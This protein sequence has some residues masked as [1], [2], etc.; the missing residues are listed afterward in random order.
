[1]IGA[2]TIYYIERRHGNA[3]D[4]SRIVVYSVR[5]CRSFILFDFRG[6]CQGGCSPGTAPVVRPVTA[7]PLA[8]R[9]DEEELGMNSQHTLIARYACSIWRALAILAA[10]AGCQPSAATTP[11]NVPSSSEASA[12]PPPPGAPSA[13]DL[14]K[15]AARDRVRVWLDWVDRGQYAQSWDTAAPLFQSSTSKV[16]WEKALQG[17][18]AP[19]GGVR[20][21]Q[22]RAAEYKSSLAGAPPG[23]Y[24]VIHYD[25]DFVNQPR[26]REIVTLRQQP[27]DSWKVAGYFVK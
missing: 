8:R 9:F 2:A 25:S 11:S 20:S 13:E 16:E 21:R 5:D 15:Q 6:L 26:A 1:M 3:A 4:L 7:A 14:A 10:T 24:V 18:R 22:L 27:D 23:N 19:L 17:A 12:L